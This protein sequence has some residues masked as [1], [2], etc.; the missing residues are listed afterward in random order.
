MKKLLAMLLIVVLCSCGCSVF[1]QDERV[2]ELDGGMTYKTGYPITKEKIELT[3]YVSETAAV[4]PHMHDTKVI[5]WIEE[6]T[7][8]RLNVKYISSD[9]QRSIMFTGRDYPDFA[10]SIGSTQQQRA[11]A[12][13]AG[14]ILQLN[15]LIDEYAPAWKAFFEAYPDTYKICADYDGSLYSLPSINY[16]PYDRDLRDCFW[17]NKVWMDELGLGPVTTI[18]EFTDVLRAFR[19]NAGKGSIPDNV[20][21]LYVYKDYNVGGYLDFFNFFGLPVTNTEFLAVI[22]GKVQYQAIQE[23]AKEVLKYLASLYKEGLIKPETFTDSWDMYLTK[24]SA[25]EAIVGAGFAYANRNYKYYAPISPLNAENGKAPTIRRQTYSPNPTHAFMMFNTN[26]YPVATIRLMNFCVED[27]EKMMNVS[28]GMRGVVWELDEN[29]LAYQ[30]EIDS[31]GKYVDYE[32]TNDAEGLYRGFG[33]SF[34]RLRT[35]EFYEEQFHNIEEEVEGTRAWAFDAF[36][37]DYLNDASLTYM[38]LPLSESEAAEM[39][40]LQAD[41]KAIRQ[42]YYSNWIMCNGDIDAQWDDFVEEMMDYELETWLALK[43]KG[44]DLLKAQ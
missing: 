21:P 16:A 13:E 32:V 36:Y 33:N 26:Q 41:L 29:G 34:I 12:I 44:Y 2:A 17:I 28:H 40:Q 15:A 27:I 1:A 22:D 31:N 11:D 35:P 24:F 8:I 30:G 10:M 43:Q 25:E 23:E 39:T 6:Q 4:R 5:D 18:S 37:K 9:D 20:I 14:D 42:N 7:N 38:S 3:V 19:D